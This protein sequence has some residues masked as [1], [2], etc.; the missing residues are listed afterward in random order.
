MDEKKYVITIGRQYGSGG[1]ALTCG[2]LTLGLIQE[3][4]CLVIHR[5]RTTAF[6]RRNVR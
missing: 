5:C 4:I 2:R 6:I 3:L 1:R